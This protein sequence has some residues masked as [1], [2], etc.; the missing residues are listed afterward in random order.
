MP[1]DLFVEVGI[2][3]DSDGRRHLTIQK[4]WER[5]HVKEGTSCWCGPRLLVVCPECNGPGCWRCE[6]DGLV[7]AVLP[8]EAVVVVHQDEEGN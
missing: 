1:G 5:P 7:D 2:V 4:A 8:G 6:G 3:Q